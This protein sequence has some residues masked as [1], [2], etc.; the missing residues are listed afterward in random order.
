MYCVLLAS[1][2][3]CGLQWDVLHLRVI[4]VV[5]LTTVNAILYTINN[6]LGKSHKLPYGRYMRMYM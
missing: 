1:Q 5:R 6:V 4:E 3:S 2:S